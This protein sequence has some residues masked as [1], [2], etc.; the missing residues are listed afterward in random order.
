MHTRIQKMKRAFMD[1]TWTELE[2]LLDLLQKKG[3]TSFEGMNIKVRLGP[4]NETEGP[5]MERV[6]EL[7][8]AFQ[9]SII[10]RD[11]LTK[12]QQEELYGQQVDTFEG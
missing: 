12:E 1:L 2:K 11:G 4:A 10:G 5:K 7:K 6:D 3:V 9:K 8:A